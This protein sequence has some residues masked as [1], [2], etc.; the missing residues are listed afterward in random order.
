MR[1]CLIP[2]WSETLRPG[3]RLGMNDSVIL[4]GKVSR[5]TLPVLEPASAGSESILKRIILPQGELAQFH[6]S[7][8]G[9]RY[10]ASIELKAGTVRGNHYHEKKREYVYIISGEILLA[11][12]DLENGAT[13]RLDLKGG[14]LILIQPRVVHALQVKHDGLAVEFSVDRFDSKDTYRR[15]CL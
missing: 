14:D 4:N 8:E 11:L 2:F 1:H 15:N 9:V 5:W 10:I 12:E 6:D 3:K 13:A 7:P